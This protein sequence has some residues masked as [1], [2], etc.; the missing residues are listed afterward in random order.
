MKII[1]TVPWEMIPDGI[2]PEGIVSATWLGGIIRGHGSHPTPL[3]AVDVTAAAC[4]AEHTASD[5]ALLL[6]LRMALGVLAAIL[7]GIGIL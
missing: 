6:A 4:R 5:L 1:E 7:L 2:V 3:R